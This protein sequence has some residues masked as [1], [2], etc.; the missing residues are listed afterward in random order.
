M[1]RVITVFSLLIAICLLSGC[2]AEPSPTIEHQKISAEEA[3]A[4]MDDR[5]PYILLDVR[6]EAEHKEQRIK[7]S[8]LI[9][10][11][12][13]DER[14]EKELPDKDTRILVYC[15]AGYRSAAAAD[16]LTY[17]GYTNVY[18]LGGIINWPYET[19]GE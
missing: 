11:D 9:P 19:A 2:G 18:D 17:L 15:R 10:V 13:I 12:E 1:K 16:N 7:G 5:N 8:I 4:M 3:K 14:A 6:T